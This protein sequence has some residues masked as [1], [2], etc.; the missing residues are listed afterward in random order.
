MTK[1]LI[2][3]ITEELATITIITLI[4]TITQNNIEKKKKRNK[5]DLIKKL[6]R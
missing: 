1:T 5:L 3:A 6:V 4:M 2:I